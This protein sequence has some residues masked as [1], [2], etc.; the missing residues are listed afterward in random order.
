MPRPMLPEEERASEFIML[1]V[2]KK[3]KT[4][5]AE[6]CKHHGINMTDYILGAIQPSIDLGEKLLTKNKE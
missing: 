6:Y 2:K 3:D 4:A 1:R 5:L